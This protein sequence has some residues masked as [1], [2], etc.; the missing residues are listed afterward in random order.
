MAKKVGILTIHNALNYG[1]TLQAIALQEYMRSLGFDCRII[2]YQN[3]SINGVY[4]RNM[5]CS[6]AA[7]LLLRGHIRSARA[8]LGEYRAWKKQSR[9][10]KILRPYDKFRKKNLRLTKPVYQNDASFFNRFD[11]LIAGSDQIWS[12]IVG[13]D[14]TY[15]L[16][17]EDCRALRIA[18]AASGRKSNIEEKID[19]I[20]RFDS[21]SVREED[22]YDTLVASGVTDVSLTCDPTMLF[23]KDFWSR[24]VGKAR[25][26]GEY[27]FAYLMFDEPHIIDYISYLEKST[28]LPVVVLHR[29]ASYCLKNG[30]KIPAATP[31]DF[32]TLLGNAKYVLTNSFHGT[33]FASL[34]EKKF[35]SYIC[36]S[37]ITALLKKIGLEARMVHH[38]E[39]STYDISEDIDWE[40][41][42]KNT[43]KFREESK[44]F[45][46][47]SFKIN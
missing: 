35:V 15:Y 8:A 4:G 43:E 21:V 10:A 42:R 2:D 25:V 44:R 5:K 30:K 32:L 47:K 27:I 41:V 18:Y 20:K 17:F 11:A 45:I 31:E 24:Y 40:D 34:F 39:Y 19:Y 36:D 7:S 9:Y 26:D 14:M 6:K 16:D 12:E 13:N 38:A 23:N 29:T 22:I 37:R 46:D 33:V 1:S 3:E 28:G